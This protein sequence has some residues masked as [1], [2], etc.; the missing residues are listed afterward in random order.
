MFQIK[1]ASNSTFHASITLNGLAKPSEGMINNKRDSYLKNIYT[2]IMLFSDFKMN[3]DLMMFSRFDHILKRLDFQFL[4]WNK[5][6]INIIFQKDLPRNVLH[7]GN[8]CL[9]QCFQCISYFCKTRHEIYVFI[10]EY[11][12][13]RFYIKTLKICKLLIGLKITYIRKMT[14]YFV[15]K[16]EI[17]LYCLYT[18]LSLVWIQV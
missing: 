17:H 12:K 4:S 3:E 14:P 15:S 13:S 16:V 9:V 6:L 2:I 5:G 7:K 11:L 8:T 18:I 10:A 1:T